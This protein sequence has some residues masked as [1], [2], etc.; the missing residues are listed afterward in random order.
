MINRVSDSN[1]CPFNPFQIIPYTDNGPAT[2]FKYENP[3]V[4]LKSCSFRKAW[5]KFP[6]NRDK[7]E[8]LWLNE[9]FVDLE[10]SSKSL[11][12]KVCIIA[13]VDLKYLWY[14]QSSTL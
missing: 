11:Y 14:F 5:A 13:A 3:N 1:F 7:K 9:S 8:L 6:H 10:V 2:K 12:L 4:V